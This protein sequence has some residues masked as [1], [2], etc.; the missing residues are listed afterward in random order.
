MYVK[1]DCIGLGRKPCTSN[2]LRPLATNT[3]EKVRP[4]AALDASPRQKTFDVHSLVKYVPF[5]VQAIVVVTTVGTEDE[6]NRLAREIVVRR[7]AACVN[8]VPVLRSVYRW[9]GKVC[10]DSEYLLII[11]SAA[12]EYPAIEAAIRE[13]HS[14]E[15]P[16]ILALPVVGGSQDY[17]DWVVK[18]CA[19]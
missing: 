6:A 18:G 14:Y 12:E 1:Y 8:I 15:L 5:V 16:E 2:H 9:K 4:G 19:P 17:L 3:G 13:L 7:H 10:E 11:K